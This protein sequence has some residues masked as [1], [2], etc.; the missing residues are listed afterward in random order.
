VE[1]F[2]AQVLH[3]P[4]AFL[5]FAGGFSDYARAMTRKL[6]REVEAPRIG[7]NDAPAAGVIR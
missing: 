2:R 1:Y 4:S 6:L 5:E 7:W 3:G